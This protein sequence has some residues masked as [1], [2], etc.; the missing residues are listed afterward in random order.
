LTRSTTATRSTVVH[1]REVRTREL[2][3]TRYEKRKRY[4]GDCSCQR[5]S[6]RRTYVIEDTAGIRVEA[7]VVEVH[8]LLYCKMSEIEASKWSGVC[9]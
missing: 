9:A 3:G 4:T 8:T 5:C 7:V 1:N 6:F 2:A